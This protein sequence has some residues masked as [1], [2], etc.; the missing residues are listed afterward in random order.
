MARWLSA[1][2]VSL[3]PMLATIMKCV[4]GRSLPTLGT[5]S[6]V[7]WGTT[8]MSPGAPLW[9]GDLWGFAL[10]PIQISVR[11]QRWANEQTKLKEQLFPPALH[12]LV[13]SQKKQFQEQKTRRQSASSLGK[14]MLHNAPW[15]RRMPK[16]LGILHGGWWWVLP[17]NGE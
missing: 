9:G 14:Q 4:K 7:Q 13:T 17:D 1:R 10:Y 15:S 2:P 3:V 11:P 5:P 12:H 8:M 6:A 16:I